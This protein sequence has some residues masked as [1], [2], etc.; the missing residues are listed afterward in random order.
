MIDIE[1]IDPEGLTCPMCIVFVCC[2]L[3]THHSTSVS[4]VHTN[5]VTL[6]PV[7]LVSPTYFHRCNIIFGAR[8]RARMCGFFFSSFRKS[9]VIYD[10]LFSSRS[11]GSSIC[12]HARM[13]MHLY[14]LVYVYYYVCVFQSFCVSV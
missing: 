13:Y 10:I 4:S 11:R 12:V 3:T 14:V 7:L 1:Q 5:R 2:C 9:V 6:V 8:V